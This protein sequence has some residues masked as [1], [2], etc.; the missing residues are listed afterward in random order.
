MRNYAGT[1][2]DICSYNLVIQLFPL[3]SSVFVVL[4]CT[5]QMHGMGTRDLLLLSLLLLLSSL[6]LLLSLLLFYFIFFIF[7]YIYLNIT[8]IYIKQ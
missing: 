5:F 3:Q 7:I 1:C 8:I 2:K 4:W 6:L